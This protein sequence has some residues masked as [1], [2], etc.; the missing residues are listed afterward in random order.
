[1]TLG[2]AL[3]IPISQTLFQTGLLKGI[4]TKR[5]QLDAHVFLQSGAT[6]IRQLLASMN[7]QG[8][9]D[10]VLQ[11]YVDGL[12]HTFWVTAACAIA[13][14]VAACGLEWKSVKKGHGKD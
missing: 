12:K 14:F 1:M 4:E 9:L 10:V 2:G 6:E 11:A 5:P 3:F 8:A 13:C 7:Q